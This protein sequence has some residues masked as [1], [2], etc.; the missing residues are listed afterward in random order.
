MTSE[1]PK[2][3]PASSRRRPEE[4]GPG[5]RSRLD[6]MGECSF[7]A[8]DPPAVWTWEVDGASDPRFLHGAEGARHE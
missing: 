5:D 2:M 6:Q 1:P 3:G 7:P 8:S 4:S